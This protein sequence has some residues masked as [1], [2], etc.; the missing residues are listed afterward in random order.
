[1]NPRIRQV[2][3]KIVERGSKAKMPIVAVT[4][5]DSDIPVV[6]VWRDLAEVL[7]VVAGAL[8]ERGGA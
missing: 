1:V 4:R 7:V 6:G 5:E 3:W 2:T 8:R